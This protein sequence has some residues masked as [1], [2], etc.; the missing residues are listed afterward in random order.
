[1]SMAS[2]E[3]EILAEAKTVFQNPKLRMKDIMEWSTG[4]IKPE[5]DEVVANGA[6]DYRRR[7]R[8]DPRHGLATR[9]DSPP[10]GSVLVP[11]PDHVW[12]GVH[13]FD[14]T[15]PEYGIDAQ[16][17]KCLSLDACIVPVVRAL[18]DSGYVTLSCCCGHG[19]GWAVITVRPSCA[20]EKP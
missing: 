5:S 7:N 11:I 8:T 12:P 19:S 9:D 10:C 1:M 14:P 6:T 13:E 20:P 18:W 2:L 17:R 16:G 4:D 3:R 15:H